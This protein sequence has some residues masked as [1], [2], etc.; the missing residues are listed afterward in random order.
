ML[1]LL[2]YAKETA[3]SFNYPP[4]MDAELYS[5]LVPNKASWN[6]FMEK[7]AVLIHDLLSQIIGFR[8]SHFSTGFLPAKA[9]IS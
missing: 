2:M 3:R 6:G 5:I 8:L 7:L 1:F 9:L 4:V